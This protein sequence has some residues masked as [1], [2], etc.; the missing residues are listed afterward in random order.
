MSE[1][2]NESLDSHNWLEI[3]EALEAELEGAQPLAA[4]F[5]SNDRQVWP[6]PSPSTP[7]PAYLEPLARQIL[8]RQQKTLKQLRANLVQTRRHIDLLQRDARRGDTDGP[9]FFDQ[10]A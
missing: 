5:I 10:E 4:G 7:L 1:E 6:V 8:E 9:R 3:L 2:S